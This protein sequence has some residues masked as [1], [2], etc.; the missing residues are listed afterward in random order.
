[1]AM[2]QAAGAAAALASQ[3]GKTP[4]EIPLDAIKAL[5][6]KHNAIVPG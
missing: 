4:L 2:G 3:S 5:L 6:R 1:M